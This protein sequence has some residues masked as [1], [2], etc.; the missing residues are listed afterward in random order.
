MPLDGRYFLTVAL[1]NFSF[2]LL[3]RYNRTNPLV[4]KCNAIC[5]NEFQIF[6]YLYI[7]VSDVS[8]Y[9]AQ[10]RGMSE[11]IQP[12]GLKKCMNRIFFVNLKNLIA[13]SY[14]LG[15]NYTEWSPLWN[16]VFVFSVA[17]LLCTRF[18]IVTQ[19]SAPI[20]N[21]F[22]FLQS[23]FLSNFCFLMRQPTIYT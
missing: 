6:F 16:L 11:S 3:K 20:V 21:Y 10:L 17:E 8:L 23:S 15:C 5:F 9:T 14:V 19:H 22:P 13:E 1:K 4:F 7:L 2:I 12:L 18:S